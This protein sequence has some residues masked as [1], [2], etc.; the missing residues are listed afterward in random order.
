MRRKFGYGW[1]LSKDFI[2]NLFVG[3]A[4]GNVINF[5]RNFV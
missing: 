3:A 5:D 1:P 2:G 4:L